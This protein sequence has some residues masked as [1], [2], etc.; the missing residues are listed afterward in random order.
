MRKFITG[1]TRDDAD[2][3]I[4]Y[5]GFISPIVLERY[6]EYMLKHQVQADGQ[7]RNSDNWQL[8]ISKDVYLK[9]L[10]RH[11]MD[12]WKIHRGYKGRDSI[13]EALCAVM[14]NTMGYLY[15]LQ[16]K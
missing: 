11:V 3:K 7:K 14:F 16:K 6:G 15:E 8:G 10:L 2:N 9:S 12:V 1:A 5:E 13:E 4:D